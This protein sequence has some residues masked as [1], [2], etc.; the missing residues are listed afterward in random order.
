MTSRSD[1]LFADGLTYFN[2]AA[3]GPTR[4]SVLDRMIKAQ[5]ELEAEPTA[6]AYGD[7]VRA[8]MEN[9]RAEAA[10]LLGCTTPEIVLTQSTTDGMN[11][12]AQ[13]LRLKTGDHVLTTDMEHEGGRVCWDHVAR[14]DGLVVDT[15]QIPLG[16][17]DAAAVV[18]RFSSAIT[19]RT[20]VIS[21]SHI[22]ASTGLRM[23]IQAL[24]ALARSR[25]ILCVVDGAQAVGGI[26]VNLKTLGCHAYATSGHKW[27]M[28]PKGT[29]IL[30]LS[31]EVN[32]V[33]APIQLERGREVYKSG[34]VRNIPGILGLGVALQSMSAFGMTAVEDRVVSLRN[35]LH[36]GL[37]GIPTIELVS[38]APGPLATALIA[39]RLRPG[40]DSLAVQTAFLQKYRTVIKRVEPKAFNGNRL[41]PHI[42]NTEREV[43]LVLER[44]R[45]ELA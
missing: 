8:E 16:A 17:N 45:A 10:R 2:T 12:I 42:F 22:I 27:L 30:Y 20:R 34:G 39:F 14:R 3:L 13:G 25:D 1:Y 11:S 29:G 36:G 7:P 21:V 5:Y 32:E 38:P 44:L 28:G 31:S 9:V 19:N 6:G 37:A 33:I 24:S 18:D 23:P 41:S 40:Q 4:R 15:V 43:D 26:D 35:R